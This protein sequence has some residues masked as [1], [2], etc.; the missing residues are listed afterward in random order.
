MFERGSGGAEG[1]TNQRVFGSGVENIESRVGSGSFSVILGEGGEGDDG[2][3]GDGQFWRF[4]SGERSVLQAIGRGSKGGKGSS[5]QLNE[6]NDTFI[7][8]VGSVSLAQPRFLQDCRFNFIFFISNVLASCCCCFHLLSLIFFFFFFSFRDNRSLFQFFLLGDAGS[9]DEAEERKRFEGEQVDQVDFPIVAEL[10]QQRFKQAAKVGLPFAAGLGAAHF[11]FQLRDGQQ[12]F[13]I[14]QRLA[15]AQH[16]VSVAVVGREYCL[17][18][19]VVLP[20]ANL[21][22]C[23]Q[24]PVFAKQLNSLS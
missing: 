14:S 10:D 9:I 3:E 18:A 19:P 22:F 16:A 7:P 20:S 4:G 21:R 6:A 24:L 17:D 13:Q 2:R 15:S 12:V 1:E 23:L 11:V 8:T 5:G